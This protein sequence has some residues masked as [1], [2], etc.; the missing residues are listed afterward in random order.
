VAA[1][2][3]TNVGMILPRSKSNFHFLIIAAY[4]FFRSL[5][6]RDRNHSA[7]GIRKI[8]FVLFAVMIDAASAPRQSSVWGLGQIRWVRK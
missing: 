4:C 5:V 7:A 6:F 8:G 3:V 2:I 1:N